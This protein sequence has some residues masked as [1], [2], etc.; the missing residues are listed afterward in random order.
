MTGDVDNPFAPI[1]E[2]GKEL[3]R[4]IHKRTGPLPSLPQDER[5]AFDRYSANKKGPTLSI[6]CYDAS[7]GSR[8]VEMFYPLSRGA[9]GYAPLIG[10]GTIEIDPEINDLVVEED[11]NVGPAG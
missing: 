8:W 3:A 1:L 5:S 9:Q 2:G 6:S 4:G 11:S 10:Q 7:V